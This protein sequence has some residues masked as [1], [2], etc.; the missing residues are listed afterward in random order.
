MIEY[1]EIGSCP[2]DEDCAQLGSKDYDY[3][4]RANIELTAYRYQLYRMFPEVS[5]TG[6]MKFA[7]KWFPHDFG[8]Y[9]E[10]VIYWNDDSEV[11]TQLAYKVE[12]NLPENWDEEAIKELSLNNIT[13]KEQVK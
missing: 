10:V 4:K 11:E 3:R 1:M 5:N 8:T 12:G 13:T 2:C 9:G 7:I 6:Q